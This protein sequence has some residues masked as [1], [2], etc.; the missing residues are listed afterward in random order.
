MIVSAEHRN[1]GDRDVVIVT[2][3][4]D[5]DRRIAVYVAPDDDQPTAVFV[6]RCA[7]CGWNWTCGE[8]CHV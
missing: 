4:G 8:G 3:P 5:D 2:D 6:H 7:D 1:Y